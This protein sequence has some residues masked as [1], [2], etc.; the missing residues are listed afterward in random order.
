M[1]MQ[2][3]RS[4]QL[5]ELAGLVVG[6]FSDMEDGSPRFGKSAEEIILDAV[7][8]FDYPVAFNAPIGH[9]ERNLA[10]YHGR[11]THLAV[12]AMGSQLVF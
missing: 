9:E 11:E 2:F 4:G 10:V 12:G 3:K 5:S 6:Q 8:E 1:L 7:R